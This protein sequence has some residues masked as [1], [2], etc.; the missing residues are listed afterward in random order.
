MRPETADV[1]LVGRTGSRMSDGGSVRSGFRIP[2]P[3]VLSFVASAFRLAQARHI[4]G[5]VANDRSV[6]RWAHCFV[7]ANSRL[8]NTEVGGAELTER[9][10]PESSTSKRPWGGTLGDG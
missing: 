2:Y 6:I 5:M 8:P 9:M 3:R 1:H 4:G 7:G 10:R